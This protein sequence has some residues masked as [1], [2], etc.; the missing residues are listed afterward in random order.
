MIGSEG[1]CAMEATEIAERVRSGELSPVEVVDAVLA[2][3]DLLEPT[4]HAF[5][6]PTPEKAREDAL[7][8]EADISAGREV[9]SLAGVPV[10]IKD[11]VATKVIKTTM[12]SRA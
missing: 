10:G 3:M 6:T 5:C 7:R 4:L 1:I 8:L 11:L 2:R 9:G 12:G